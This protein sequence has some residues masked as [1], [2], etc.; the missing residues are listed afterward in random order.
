[1]TV[2]LLNENEQVVEEM[3]DEDFGPK[4]FTEM[5]ILAL[6]LLLKDGKLWRIEPTDPQGPDGPYPGSPDWLITRLR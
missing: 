1:M 5:R 6:P 3:P 4:A 2:Q